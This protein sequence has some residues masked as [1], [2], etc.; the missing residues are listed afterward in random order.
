MKNNNIHMIY[1]GGNISNSFY[2][3]DKAYINNYRRNYILLNYFK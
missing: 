1:I 2:A 3:A